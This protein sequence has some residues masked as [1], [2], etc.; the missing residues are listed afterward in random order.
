MAAEL[1]NVLCVKHGQMSNELSQTA[2]TTIQVLH[3]IL[4]NDY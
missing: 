2:Q 1:V 3:I 4:H